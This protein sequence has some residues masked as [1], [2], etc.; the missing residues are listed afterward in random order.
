MTV[1]KQL[2]DELAHAFTN[3]AM[4]ARLGASAAAVSPRIWRAVLEGPLAEVLARPGKAFRYNLVR[5]GYQLAGGRGAPPIELGMIV[6]ILHAG[7]LIIDDIQDGSTQ[8]RG[9]PALHTSVG[10]PLALNAGNW[11]YFWPFEILRQAPLAPSRTA[12]ALAHLENT[13]LRCHHGQA[14]DLGCDVTT[15]ASEELPQVVTAIA[16]LKS[17]ALMR[18]AATL[19]ALAAPDAPHQSIDAAGALGEA[20]GVGLQRLDD[21]GN[22]LGR[23]DPAKQYEDLRLRRATWPWAYLARTAPAEL[24]TWQARLRAGGEAELA[25]FATEFHARVG[26]D[27]HAHAIT[28]L[29]QALLELRRC[30]AA[31]DVE[32]ALHDLTH[33]VD[34]LKVAY[35]A[36]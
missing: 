29:E 22:L 2:T 31:H 25:C 9:L 17:G 27:A 6:E 30:M 26:R 8:R 33:D 15:L 10:V 4:R 23:K 5:A 24:P 18:L 34:R 19:G 7:S 20:L 28:E 14:L 35:D 16:E 36:I 11:A 1:A 13:L 3:V 21:L 12:L 32:P